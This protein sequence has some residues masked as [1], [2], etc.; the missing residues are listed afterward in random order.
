MT[1]SSHQNSQTSESTPV[2]NFDKICKC[3]WSRLTKTSKPCN[4]HKSML[5]VTRLNF[6]LHHQFTL[7]PF[8]LPQTDNFC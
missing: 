1:V 8:I 7:F 6:N 3:C 2:N 5:I 4:A